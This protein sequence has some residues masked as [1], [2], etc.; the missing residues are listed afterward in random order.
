MFKQLVSLAVIPAVFAL[1]T[2]L[3]SANDIE[4]KT[5][6]MQVSV[7]NG[8][9]QV[10]SGSSAAKNSSWLNRLSNLRIFNGRSSSSSVGSN[11]N[12]DRR[13]SGHSTTSSNS[14][15]TATSRST[16]TSTSMTC[17]N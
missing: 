5:G 9:V 16:S 13:S 1:S 12:C 15:G 7:Q 2:G 4:V 14:S 17:S 3:A 10:N 8:K 11:M 6:N